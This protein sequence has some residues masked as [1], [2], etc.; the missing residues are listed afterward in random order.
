MA[1]ASAVKERL[2]KD[3]SAQASPGETEFFSNVE[4]NSPPGHPAKPD[5]IQKVAQEM[6]VSTSTLSYAQQHLKAVERYPELAAAD[7]SRAEVLPPAAES[8]G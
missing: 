8:G 6:G 5:A 3:A 4:K 2:S 7:L 1:L